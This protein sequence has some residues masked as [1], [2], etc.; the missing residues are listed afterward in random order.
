MQWMVV[1]P[2]EFIAGLHTIRY[3]D[4]LHHLPDA[5]VVTVFLIAVFG[6]NLCGVRAFGEAEFLASVIKASA[7]VGF[8]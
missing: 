3:W 4:A 1:V 2:L 5:A 8:M 6:V 7:V